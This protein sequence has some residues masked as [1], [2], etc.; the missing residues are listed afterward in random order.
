[1]RTVLIL[2]VLL[3]LNFSNGFAQEENKQKDHPR[4]FKEMTP[5]ERAEK[6]TIKMTEEL[7]LTEDQATRIKAVNLA[8][9]K[10]ME[11]LHAE[12]KVL[13]DQMK[14][15]RE[16]TKKEIDSVLTDAQR[17][18]MKMR[19]EEHKKKREQH[20]KEKCCHDKE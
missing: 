20:H 4:E 18:K 2:T 1:M 13:K 8:H 11:R 9:A 15:E 10:E 3:G 12:F 7:G 14:A 5:E 17:E 16:K 19:E 6:R